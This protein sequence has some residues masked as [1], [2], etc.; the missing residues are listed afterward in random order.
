[1]CSFEHRGQDG[2]AVAVKAYALLGFRQHRT[3]LVHDAQLD[4][5]AADVNTKI[6]FHSRHSPVLFLCGVDGTGKACGDL[7]RAGNG[8]AHHQCKRTGFQCLD[9]LFR[10]VDVTFGNDLCRAL[11]G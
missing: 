2:G 3:G 11:C 7:C 8:T 6:V 9:R 1:M 4:G 5:S 10:V